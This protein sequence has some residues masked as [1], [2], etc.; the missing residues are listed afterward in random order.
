MTLLYYY[1]TVKKKH[2]I[3]YS[4]LLLRFLKENRL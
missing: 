3:Y 1:I 2:T 4:F